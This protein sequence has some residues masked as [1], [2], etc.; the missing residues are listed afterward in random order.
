MKMKSRTIRATGLSLSALLTALA[1]LA[2]ACGPAAP[3]ASAPAAPA[4]NPASAPAA[5]SAASA[6]WEQVVAAAKRE[7]KISIRGGAGTA[8][9][10]S[11]TEG[12][13]RKYPEIEVDYIGGEANQIAPRL[14]QEQAAGLY[15]VDLLVSGS[16]S[17]L[18]NYVPA[19]IVVPIRPFLVGPNSSD[20]SQWLGGRFPFADDAAIYNLVGLAYVK[21][22][23]IFNPTLV[24]EDGFSSYRDLLDPKWRGKISMLQPGVSGPAV[25]QATFWYLTPTLGKEF[26]TE[27]FT[28]QNLTFSQNSDQLVDWAAR[29][30]Y[31]ISIAPG[32]L[33]VENAMDKGLP[34]KYMPGPAMREGTYLTSGNSTLAVLRG[35]PH[36]N[37]LKVYLDWLLSRDGLWEWSKGSGSVSLRRD[38]PNDHVLD[39][40]VPKEGVQYPAS[41]SETYVRMAPEVGEFLRSL[42]RN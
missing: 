29:G 40:K 30:Q 11:L 8:V 23:F 33:Q 34:I 9:R 24:S 18:G 22:P 10:D 15:V 39:F 2:S 14:L 20:E 38:V 41:H 35:H 26:I 16:T 4:A 5:Q 25:T 31:P 19:G 7:G 17:V 3:T 36:P 12:F 27:L 1:L 21:A 13:S 6:E 37:A 42:I 28:N 32:D